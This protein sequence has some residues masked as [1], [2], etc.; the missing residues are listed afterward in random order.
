MLPPDKGKSLRPGTLQHSKREAVRTPFSPVFLLCWCNAA[1]AGEVIAKGQFARTFYYRKK[2][3]FMRRDV[4]GFGSVSLFV[5]VLLV[6]S[7]WALSI[8][9]H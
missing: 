6:L 1:R 7:I 9:P 4:L 5:L 3:K 2:R 8:P